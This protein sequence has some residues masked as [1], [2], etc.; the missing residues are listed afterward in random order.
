MESGTVGRPSPSQVMEQ[1]PK[2]VKGQSGV[3]PRNWAHAPIL[4]TG[5]C[6]GA[7][8]IV[9][10]RAATDGVARWEAVSLSGRV[11]LCSAFL[12]FSAALGPASGE[13]CLPCC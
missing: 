9:T 1:R 13:S 7:C 3:L 5:A 2:T 6:A 12:P 4:G 10:A 8:G 11:T